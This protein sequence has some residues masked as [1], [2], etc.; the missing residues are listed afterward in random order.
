MTIAAGQKRSVIN[1]VK[2]NAE[3]LMSMTAIGG[4]TKHKNNLDALNFTGIS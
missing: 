4:N 2:R 3:K 1:P